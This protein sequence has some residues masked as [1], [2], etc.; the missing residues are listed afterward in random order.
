MIALLTST[1]AQ[2]AI[3]GSVNLLYIS[4]G[5]ADVTLNG[6][7]AGTSSGP[8]GHVPLK[9]KRAK[10]LSPATFGILGVNHF[11]LQITRLAMTCGSFS[12]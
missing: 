9:I 6:G 4:S 7:R 5:H 1:L 10:E 8:D 12:A 11:D 2:A 3:N